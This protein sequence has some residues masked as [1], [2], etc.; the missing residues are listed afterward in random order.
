M[1]K[2]LEQKWRK[3][4]RSIWKEDNGYLICKN[5]P[6]FQR[7]RS[8]ELDSSWWRRCVNNLRV[9]MQKDR[10]ADYTTAEFRLFKRSKLQQEFMRGDVAGVENL[11]LF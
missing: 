9:F 7:K 10:S 2:F 3:F 4:C 5:T 8:R 1:G 11:E 6:V